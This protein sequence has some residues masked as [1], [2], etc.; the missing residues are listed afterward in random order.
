VFCVDRAPI[1]DLIIHD[2]T[3]RLFN[4]RVAKK[5]Q[6]RSPASITRLTKVVV[7]QQSLPSR[8]L[9]PTRGPLA[10]AACRFAEVCDPVKLSSRKLR[11]QGVA[12]EL[13][14]QRCS[15]FRESL[16]GSLP[17]TGVTTFFYA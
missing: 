4:M 15:A 13:M 16:L 14:S 12:W 8:S 7:E 17:S 11:W 10:G 1:H 6:I 2:T 5:Q 9:S 3:C